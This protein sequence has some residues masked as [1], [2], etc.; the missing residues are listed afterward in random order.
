MKYGRNERELQ[1]ARGKRV[2]VI[3]LTGGIGSGKTVA[4]HALI[5]HG[6]FVIDADEISRE[7]FA[8]G[9]DGERRILKLFPTAARED[10]TLNRKK[11]RELIAYDR[12]ARAE[13]N[14]L[15]HK[16]IIAEV[17][18]R[19]ADAK[20]D[21][22]VVISAPLLLESGLSRLCDA[23]VCIYCP[24]EIR[25]ERITKRDGVSQR[26]ARAIIDA[27]IP[28]TERATLCDYI[29]PSDVPLNEFTSEVLA[30]FNQLAKFR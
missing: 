4:T 30:L 9:T 19:V 21:S 20:A 11:L 6:F 8:V 15:T 27:Q 25:I 2:G 24:T 26:E 7:M 18:R 10:G 28:D 3:G 5:S 13:L 16:A 12:E 1:E 23:V 17:E 22:Q 14:A 29:I